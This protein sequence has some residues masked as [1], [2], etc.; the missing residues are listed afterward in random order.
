MRK[1]LAL[2]LLALGL[3]VGLAA[4]V[5]LA[6]LPAD[7][8]PP[9]P[10]GRI[11]FA[12]SDRASEGTVTYT[13]NPDGSHVKPLFS[14]GP[15]GE[16]RWSPDGSRIAIL[17]ACTDGQE[18]C[19]ATIVNP[20]TGAVRQLKMTDPTLFAGCIVWSPD[21]ERLACAGFGEPDSSRNGIYTIRSS[22]GGGLT[23]MT[24]SP[25]GSDMPGDY[26]P[27][28][29]RLVFARFDQN[30]E[31]VGLYVVKTNGSHL[32][33]ITPPGTIA[34]SS[35]DW[36]PQGNAIVFARRVNADMRNSLWVVDSDGSGLHEI[37]LQ[38]QPA[39]GG[40][41]SDPASRACIHPRWSPDGKK[42]IFSI[43]TETATDEVENVYTVNADGTGL[44]QV[45]HGGG[46]DGTSDWGTHPLVP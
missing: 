30:D 15:S 20:D 44:T 27:E 2:G 25:R 35:G 14:D 16:P 1:L 29:K 10:N 40:P 41:I 34:S 42:I 19:A 45:T 7:A 4:F 28:G 33:R 18:N 24:S 46:T 32:R 5:A 3:L 11:A 8:K 38:A 13:A 43:V 39:C 22:D 37:R 23:R 12:V 26:S 31:P 9:G 6:V 36:S 21:G 17:A